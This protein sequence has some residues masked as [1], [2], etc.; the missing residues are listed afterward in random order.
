M[1][2][3][4]ALISI[5][6]CVL[7]FHLY[8][9][10]Q[11][12]LTKLSANEKSLWEAIKNNDMN[13]FS[14]ATASDLLEID[15][16]G[17]VMNKQQLIDSFK[18]FKMTDYTLTDFK[19]FTLDKNAV[20]LSYTADSSGTMNGQTMQSKVTHTTTY[21]MKDGKWWPKFHTETPVVAPPSGAQTQ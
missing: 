5:F 9:A 11:D 8:A 10:D 13:A 21:I 19:V 7:S 6:F 3:T 4:V 2:K 20:V 12:L 16:M 17:T 18:T 14:A 15:P 1:N